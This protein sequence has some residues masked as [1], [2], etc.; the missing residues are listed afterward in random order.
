MCGVPARGGG[1]GG[2]HMPRTSQKAVTVSGELYNVSMEWTGVCVLHSISRCFFR[3]G[4]NPFRHMSHNSRASSQQ[5]RN[6]DSSCETHL[7][8]PCISVN[9]TIIIAEGKWKHDGGGD[10]DGAVAF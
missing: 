6:G 7:E 3:G 10:G 9:L 1:R 4:G 5:S 8:N 2:T